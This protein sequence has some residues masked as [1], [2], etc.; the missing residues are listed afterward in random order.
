MNEPSSDDVTSEIGQ[1]ELRARLENLEQQTAAALH[2]AKRRIVIAEMKVEATRA[3]M[4]DL[5][6][7]TFLDLNRVDLGD[8]G[9]LVGGPAVIADLKKAK[10]WLFSGASSSSTSR[11]P[12]SL[13]P[14]VKLATE[15]TDAEYR[16]ARKNIIA[17]G[18][19]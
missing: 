6:G 15:M 9:A 2:D 12:P 16:I 8:D 1:D 19:F 17:R 13:P 5:D 10:P 4:V 3:G 14:R 7:L 11:P 18:S